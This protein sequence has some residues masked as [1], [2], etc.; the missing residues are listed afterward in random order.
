MLH[1]RIIRA[2]EGLAGKKEERK[3][4]NVIDFSARARKMREEKELD[5]WMDQL[6]AGRTDLGLVD[7]ILA[8]ARAEAE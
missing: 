6:D 7:E 2:G 8:K 5:K 4:G 1:T 3:M